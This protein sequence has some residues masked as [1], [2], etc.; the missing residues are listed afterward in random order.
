MLLKLFADYCPRLE[1]IIWNH[2]STTNS[3]Y[4][5]ATRRN[6]VPA[7]MIISVGNEDVFKIF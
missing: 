1:T 3:R 6:S 4:V 5:D 2:T 7:A